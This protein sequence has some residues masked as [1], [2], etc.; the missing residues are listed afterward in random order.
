MRY[1]CQALRRPQPPLW[2]WQ[3]FLALAHR[4]E[5]LSFAAAARTA[6]EPALRDAAARWMVARGLDEE[7]AEALAQVHGRR[8]YIA[9]TGVASASAAAEAAA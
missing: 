1:W 3:R 2:V 7:A 4:D 5:T 9:P 6:A 8:W